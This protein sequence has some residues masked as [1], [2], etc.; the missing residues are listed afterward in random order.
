MAQGVFRFQGKGTWSINIAGRIPKNPFD[1]SLGIG[2]LAEDGPAQGKKTS[3]LNF[4][5]I[6]HPFEKPEGFGP[7][8]FPVREWAEKP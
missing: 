5:Q 3:F 1:P 8:A 2:V 7:E 4:I 6:R